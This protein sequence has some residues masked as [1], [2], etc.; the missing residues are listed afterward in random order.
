MGGLIQL[1]ILAAFGI[2]CAWIASNRGRSPVAWFL[3]GFFSHVIGLIIL[4]VLPDLCAQQ[5]REQR[6][7]TENRRLRERVKKDRQVADQRHREHDER[8][9]AHDRALGMDTVSRLPV[10]VASGILGPPEIPPDGPMDYRELEW[11]YVRDGSRVG[12]VSLD[13]LRTCWRHGLVVSGTLVWSRD[14]E[15]WTRVGDLR[16]L[17]ERLVE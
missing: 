8:L 9:T 5:E 12:P 6:L 10:P 11:F 13:D 3:I 16:Q 2:C 14:L 17:E 15:E 1:A 7:R 4:M